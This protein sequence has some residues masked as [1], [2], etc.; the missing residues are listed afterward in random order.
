VNVEDAIRYQDM[1]SEPKQV[2]WYESEH[3]PLPD[4][5]IRDS[6]KWLQEFIG[7]GALYL[8]PAPNYRSSAVIIDRLLRVCLLLAVLSL[9]ILIV[10]RTRPLD[11][12]RGRP[13]EEGRTRFSEERTKSNKSIDGEV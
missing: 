11:S 7:P 4:G 3:W 10:Y 6:A 13:P 1:A 9:A 5:A 8:V 2:I 12:S